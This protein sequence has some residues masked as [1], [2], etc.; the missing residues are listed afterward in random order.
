MTDHVDEKDNESSEKEQLVIEDLP[1]EK[2]L[3]LY[4][5]LL[6]N[7][8]FQALE[9]IRQEKV[10]NQISQYYERFEE[11]GKVEFYDEIAKDISEL[12]A[13]NGSRYFD[14]LPFNIGI[15]CDEFLYHSYKD[16]AMFHYIS[17]DENSLREDLDFI[18]IATTWKGLDGSWSGVASP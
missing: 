15:V 10:Y 1:I 7:N 5:K 18:I 4:L 12:P 3:N 13:S 17:A 9:H 8:Y 6:K 14:K 2:R 16:A 11:I